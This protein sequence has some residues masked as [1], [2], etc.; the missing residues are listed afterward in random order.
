MLKRIL[1]CLIITLTLATPSPHPEAVELKQLDAPEVIMRYEPALESAA[2]GLAAVYPGIRA[3]VENK[4]A[5]RI[6]F[7]PVVVLIRRHDSFLRESRNDLVTAFAVPGEDLIAIDY[8]SME[9]TPFDLRSTLAHELCHLL[10]HRN[11]EDPALPRW[12]DEG[13]A[14]WVGGGMD[15]LDTGEK[16]VLKQ[17]VLAGNLLRLS[18]ISLHFPEQSR[19]L[20]LSYEESR[21]LVEFIVREY[22]TGK[23]LSILE[24]LHDG[25]TI[26]QAVSENLQVGLATLEGNWRNSLLKNYSWQTYLAD[27]IYWILFFLAAL[28][29]ICGYLRLRKR[30]KNYRDEGDEDYLDEEETGENP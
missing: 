13:I 24:G 1:L 23:L 17:A 14:Q 6:G 9:R 30:F 21:S 10:L 22:G 29:T 7:V 15:I 3:D 28:G 4:L 16:D 18:D 5:W 25:K 2:V 26:E 27:H 12:L 11:I 20:R 19:A 8:S